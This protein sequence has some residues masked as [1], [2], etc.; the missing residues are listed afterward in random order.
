M[1]EPLLRRVGRNAEPDGAQRLER[2]R[3]AETDRRV[4]VL[5]HAGALIGQPQL[6]GAD[7]DNVA[8]GARELFDGERTIATPM[9]LRRKRPMLNFRSRR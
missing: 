7:D 4:G 9:A 5:L 6:R 3:L 2:R 8:N 1:N